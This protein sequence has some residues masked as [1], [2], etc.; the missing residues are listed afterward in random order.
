VA[1]FGGVGAGVAA[2]PG[3]ANAECPDRRK[4]GVDRYEC[5]WRLTS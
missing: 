4:K 5:A 3:G 2:R 1:D